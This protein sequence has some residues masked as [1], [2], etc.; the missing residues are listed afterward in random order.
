MQIAGIS[1]LIL[2][3]VLGGV[4]VCL[5]GVGVILQVFKHKYRSLLKRDRSDIIKFAFTFGRL[6]EM[7]LANF[8]AKQQAA[9]NTDNAQIAI[10]ITT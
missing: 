9:R 7:H 3:A 10:Y 4:Y 5:A 1:P 2:A 6:A 8:R